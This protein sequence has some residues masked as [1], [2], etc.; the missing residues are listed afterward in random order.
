VRV[1]VCFFSAS[2]FYYSSKQLKF[3]YANSASADHYQ[4]RKHVATSLKFPFGN[5]F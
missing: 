5:A 1:Y 3:E 2:I 4:K